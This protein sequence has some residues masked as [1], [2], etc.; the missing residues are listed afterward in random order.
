MFIKYINKFV[1]AIIALTICFS[2]SSSSVGIFVNALDI[3]QSSD[4]PEFNY[5]ALGASNVNGYGLHGY[6][7]EYVYESP[8]EKA[9]DNRY[10]YEMDTPGAYA[11]II[12]E[13][14]SRDYNVNLH[15]I[16]TSSL[17]AEELHFLLDY[18]YQGDAYTDTWFYDTN[19]DGVSSNWYLGG[20]LYEWQQCVD[21]NLE[22]FD[23]EPTPEELLYNLRTACREKVADA[24]LITIDIGMNNF[25]TY[26]L[27]LISTGVFS[28]DLESLNPEIAHYY[29]IASEYALEIIEETIGDT[30][31]PTSMLKSF[32]DT[33]AYALVG[34]CVNF[35]ETIK[36]I[37]SLNPDVKIVVVSIQNMLRDLDVVFP[38]STIRVPFG[39]IF[40]T[41]INAANLYTAT[42]SPYSSTY[43]YANVSSNGH[44]E[45]F[46]D[47]VGAYD[48]NPSS[49][50]TNLKDCF[51][52]YDGSLYIKTRIQQ[53]FAVNMSKKGLVRMDESQKDTT[54]MESIEAFH[55]GFHYGIEG[56]EN[57][58]KITWHDGTPLKDFIK[59]GEAG[60]LSGDDKSY[61][62]IYAKMLS[63]AYD[64]V[65]EVLRESTKPNIMD[66]TQL[67]V[68]S[69]LGLSTEQIL[70]EELAA[71]VENAIENPDYNYDIN[72]LY[73]EGYF[74]A[75]AQE[76]NL[77]PIVFETMFAFAMRMQFGGTVFS[78]PNANGYKEISKIIWKTYIKGTKGADVIN[79][80]L[81]IDYLPTDSSYYVA[82]NGFEGGYAD[83]FAELIGLENNQVGYTSFDN[84]DYSEIAKADIVSIG[85]NEADMINFVSNQMLGYVADYIDNDARSIATSYVSTIVDILS[86]SLSSYISL[87]G[88]KEEL[89]KPV[90]NM[91]DE[92]LLTEPIANKSKQ[93]LDWSLLLDEE[94]V[95]YVELT[96]KTLKELVVNYAGFEYYTLKID[97]V[98]LLVQN[99]ASINTNPFVSAI[100]SNPDTLYTMFGENSF[101]TIDLPLTDAIVFA[102]E[103]FLYRY[104]EETIKSANLISYINTNHPDTKIIILGRYNLLKDSYLEIGND[105]LDIGYFFEALSLVSTSQTLLYFSV[106][107]NTAFANIS[108]TTTSYQEA[109]DGQKTNILDLLSLY[110]LDQSIL[111][112]GDKGN[113][114]IANRMYS[115]IRSVCVHQFNNCEDTE[116]SLCGEEID[117]REHS[118]GDWEAVYDADGNYTGEDTRTCSVCNH[119]DKRTTSVIES[120]TD[121]ESNKL[122]NPVLPI[123]L[124][125]AVICALAGFGVY[126]F[127][128]RKKK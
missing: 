62:E 98:E 21:K 47:E 17:R 122:K 3:Q 65:A 8:F 108:E 14:L 87:A 112:I 78:H 46:F 30:V 61:Y 127:I 13:K 103:S 84:I 5:V 31:M 70:L 128:V 97:M 16:A 54:N 53:M 77:E 15:Q 111:N 33:I 90:N 57:T 79:D 24:D 75:L 22:G 99:A 27:N 35:D 4:K 36:E 67:G 125:A 86:N 2:A 25:G 123:T 26:M 55:Y 72:E 76:H 19:G 20:A 88:L 81:S 50:S 7:F 124:S 106:F 12:K 89:K 49:L 96:K 120:Q 83:I 63:V 117:P 104:M 94:Q 119:I 68:A 58:P 113:E 101:I 126:Y 9:K 10:G 59:K 109:N 116:C 82:I 107:N 6:N 66:F 40:G 73:P 45:F 56:K 52:V 18:T 41:I 80:Q 29:K 85:Y 48:G 69:Y 51:N 105:R 64:V 37:Y 28:S 95:Q 92:I 23:H 43:Y 71:A 74:N 60:Q 100:I 93:D 91:I 121:T 110:N 115:Q 118:Y 39:D 34:Y 11:D 114:Y 38:G 102:L 42:L 32:A 1:A 44:T